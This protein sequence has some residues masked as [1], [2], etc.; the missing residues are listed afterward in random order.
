MK[1]KILRLIKMVSKFTIYGILLQTISLTVL[2]ASN[3]IAQ[4]KSVKEV[5]IEVESSYGSLDDVFETIE[6]QTNYRFAYSKDNISNSKDLEIEEGERNVY[7]ILIEVSQKRKLKF[8]QINNSISVEKIKQKGRSISGVVEIAQTISISGKVTSD[9]DTEGLP[10]VNVIVK[11][12]GQGTVTDVEGIYVVEVPNSQAILT[13]S[14]VGFVTQEL[15]VGTQSIINITL[16]ADITA[17]DEIV[18]VGYGTQ[19]K[20]SLCLT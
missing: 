12:T 1:I 17:L 3:G 11:G 13:F 4:N 8:T 19:K 6:A 18:V 10:G 5:Y 7:D 20:V 9:V 15:T 16:I 14:S 2:L